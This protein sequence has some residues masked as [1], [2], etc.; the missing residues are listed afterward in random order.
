MKK[1]I[2]NRAD[3]ELLISN[4]YNKVKIDATIGYIFTDI[5]NL[6]WDMLFVSQIV[7]VLP[8]YANLPAKKPFRVMYFGTSVP[9]RVAAQRVES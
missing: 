4:F 5:F 3:I 9:V 7:S 6:N 8:G 2:E 1:D